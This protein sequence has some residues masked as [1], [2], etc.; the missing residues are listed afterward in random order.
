MLAQDRDSLERFAADF[1]MISHKSLANGLATAFL[2]DEFEEEGLV[3]RGE[4]LLGRRWRWLRPLAKRIVARFGG[5]VRPTHRDVASFILGDRTFRRACECYDFDTLNWPLDRAAFLPVRAAR[6]W[7]VPE[8]AS[9]GELVDWLGITARELDWFA[10]L[11]GFEGKAQSERLRHYRYRLLTKPGGG[12]RL[13]EAPKPRL[14]ELQ[15]RILAV[16]LDRV[17]PHDAAHGFRP[18]RSIRS[19]AAPHVGRSVVLKID[20]CDFFPTVR[21]ARVRALFRAVGY[22]ESV[23]DSLAGLCMNVAPE[24]AWR[25]G[26]IHRRYEQAMRD[27]YGRLHLP[28]GAPTSPAL[29]NLAA[30]RLDNRL[31]GLARAAGATYTRYADDLAFSGNADFARIVHRFRHH[32]CATILEEGFQ[33]NFRKTR[34][35]RDGVRQHLAGLVVNGRVNIRRADYDRLKATLTNCARFGSDSQNRDNHPEFRAHLI[36]R[37]AFVASVHPERGK[38]L[39]AILDQINWP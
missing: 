29:A 27:L 38:R 18:R 6:D 12:V 17:P 33:P 20:L 3:C 21:A 25:C 23:A 14:K 19:F 16:I 35:M 9:I 39:R 26:P 11:R 7:R 34:I 36:G 4:K 24:P 5:G 15:R 10:D 37:V 1:S 2:L 32:V 13:I 8:L 28:Q 31:S 22:P 30:Y